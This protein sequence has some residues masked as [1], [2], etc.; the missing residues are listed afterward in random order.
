VTRPRLTRDARK[1]LETDL[2]SVEKLEALQHL[3]RVPGEI[4]RSELVRAVNLERETMRAAIGDLVRAGFID[5]SSKR[6][7]LRLGLRAMGA[8]Y[9][10]VMRL[11][12]EDRAL[13]AAALSSIAVER[14]RGMAARAFGEALATKKK[15]DDDSD[16]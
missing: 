14:I 16:R 1:L 12:D 9:E 15:S 13:I 4:L 6:G 5:A 7:G 8:A 10:D 3:G 2:D 11:Y